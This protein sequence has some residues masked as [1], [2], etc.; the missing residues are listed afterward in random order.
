MKRTVQVNVKMSPEDF[1]LLKK[2][3]EKRWPDELSECYACG[4][5]FCGSAKTNCRSIYDCDR[6]AAYLADG[7]AV[8]NA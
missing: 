1:A 6:L 5:K 8:R 4:G 3:A 2:A 7:L